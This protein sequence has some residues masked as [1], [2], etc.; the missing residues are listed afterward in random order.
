MSVDEDARHT[1]WIFYVADLELEMFTRRPSL[2]LAF[3]THSA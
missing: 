2:R 1:C 3:S